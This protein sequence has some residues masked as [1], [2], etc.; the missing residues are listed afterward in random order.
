MKRMTPYFLTLLLVFTLIFL[1]CLSQSA[2][3][4]EPRRGSELVGELGNPEVIVFEGLRTYD[5]NE[6]LIGL[7]QR[8]DF[9]LASHPAGSLT[10]YLS[11]LEHMIRAGYQRGGFLEATATAGIHPNAQ[12]VLLR[13][14]EG[15]RYTCGDVRVVGGRTLTNE[16]IRARLVQALAETGNHTRI[17]NDLRSSTENGTNRL[18]T[19]RRTNELTA[20]WTI[21]SPAPCDEAALGELTKQIEDLLP[22]LGYFGAKLQLSLQPDAL[23]RR[24]ELWIHVQD[25][26]LRGQI[27]GFQVKGNR[28][29]SRE[30]VLKFLDLEPGAQASADLLHKLEGRLRDSARFLQHDLSLTPLSEP[31]RLKLVIALRELKEAPPLDQEFTPAIK[32]W[33]KFRDWLSDF[34]NHSDDLVCD[35]KAGSP[36]RRVRGEAFVSASGLVF[37]FN[38]SRQDGTLDFSY[39][40]VASPRHIGLYSGARRRSL[41]FVPKRGQL[42]VFAKLAPNPDPK[43][44]AP[45]NLS[46]GA[47]LAAVETDQPFRPTIDLVPVGF[48]HRAP[49]ALTN[50]ML[51]AESKD[52]EDHSRWQLKVAAATGRLESGEYE[53]PD[54]SMRVRSESGVF[55]RVISEIATATASYQ[56]DSAEGRIWE[57]AISFVAVD[58][59]RAASLLDANIR[60]TDLDRLAAVV[61]KLEPGNWLAPL[62]DL[63]WSMQ[64]PADESAFTVPAENIGPDRS[65]EKT[66][67]FANL[68][69][70]LLVN[71]DALWPRGSWPWTA[72]R[73]AVFMFED[74]PEYMGAE[75]LRL[76]GSEE[77]GLLGRWMMIDIAKAL[78]PRLGKQIARLPQP[79][80]SAAA[81][82]KDW[83]LLLR[84]DTRMGDVLQR[85]I[86]SLCVL[87][88]QELAALTERLSPNEAE[89]IGQCV[90][91]MRAA[92]D[93]SVAETLW[94][95]VEQH[96]ESVVRPV[97]V[98]G[99]GP[100]PKE[101]AKPARAQ[102]KPA[103]PQTPKPSQS[104][105]DSA[106][107]R[108]KGALV[109]R[110]G[111]GWI[112]LA[113]TN[114]PWMRPRAY[115]QFQL[116]QSALEQKDYALAGKAVRRIVEVWPFSD[117]APRAYYILGR[118]YEETKAGEL[119]DKVAT[120]EAD[121][122]K[123]LAFLESK[124][125]N[126]W[127]T[128]YARSG[129]GAFFLARNNYKQA[130]PLLLAGYEGM[131]AHEA[132]IPAG[133]KSGF[134]EALES[135][136]QWLVQLYQETG[137]PE[138]AAEWK[139]K[140]P[141]QSG[142]NST[143]A[144]EQQVILID[145]GGQ[146]LALSMLPRE[147]REQARALF[148]KKINKD[149]Q[150]FPNSVVFGRV[151]LPD[152]ET[153][154]IFQ[155]QL[156]GTNWYGGPDNPWSDPTHRAQGK[157]AFGCQPFKEPV[158]LC[159][160]K[161][162]YKARE[163]LLPMMN[164]Q[165]T[166]IWLGD[167]KLEKYAESDRRMLKGEL[168]NR[169]QQLLDQV[170]GEASLRL[171][172]AEVERKSVI[173][174]GAF[175]FEDVTPGEYMIEFRLKGYSANTWVAKVSDGPAEP[176]KKITGYPSYTFHF[177]V[178]PELH[179]TNA[180]V[181]AGTGFPSA[182]LELGDDTQLRIKQEG[183]EISL[184]CDGTRKVALTGKLQGQ[185]ALAGFFLDVR[186]CQGPFSDLSQLLPSVQGI[187]RF[188]KR[189]TYPG[190]S[191]WYG[192]LQEGDVI[193]VLNE[194]KSEVKYAVE[195]VKRE[196]PAGGAPSPTPSSSKV[197]RAEPELIVAIAAVV[198]T[199][200]ILTSDIREFVQPSL[201]PLARAYTNNPTVL[202][203]K[204]YELELH[205][206]DELVERNLI[207]A[208]A[209]RQDM[210]PEAK[211]VQRELVRVIEDRYFDDTN[212]FLRTIAAQGVTE[213]EYLRSI[214]ENMLVQVLRQ[215]KLAALPA[216]SP[217]QV[218]DY[219]KTNLANFTTEE[220]VKLRLIALNKS[221]EPGAPSAKHRA[222]EVLAQLNAGAPFA[223][224]AKK[225]S[226]E[227]HREQWGE[228][229]WVAKSVL[230]KEL[231]EVTFSLRPGEHSVVVETPEAS[232][233]VLVEEKRA[234]SVQPL[235]DVRNEIDK[236]L[237]T[238]QRQ[239]ALRSWIDEMRSKCFVRYPGVPSLASKP[240]PDAKIAEIEIKHV[241]AAPTVSDQIIRLTLQAR[242][243]ERAV[244]GHLDAD[245]RNLYAM[246]EFENI[247]VLEQTASGGVKLIYVLQERPM[248]GSVKFNGNK[249][250]STQ[251][252][253][254]RLTSK[255]GER[256]D[257]RK[258]LDDSREF[259]EMLREAEFP[260]AIVKYVTGLDQ[261]TGLATVTF[262]VKEKSE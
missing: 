46:F 45:L 142:A 90:R 216:P 36:P 257:E 44:K 180:I 63:D 230:R 261:K 26:G 5:R 206:L 20:T 133:S 209:E 24:A 160:R 121:Y 208:E 138:Q 29:N 173:Q 120:T 202:E 197:E 88:D 57:S 112:Y 177:H 49:D 255:I 107:N 236:L 145:S 219:Y 184:S 39:A 260:K 232:Y 221:A 115:E 129:F 38:P 229:G 73:E 68:R 132:K 134:A 195:V 210:R 200:P 127:Q 72:A 140:L 159:I 179:N 74:H 55:A 170:T 102:G 194:A 162:G 227:S 35:F 30:Q 223:E 104:G 166:V 18:D 109:Y 172:S 217:E 12:Q 59:I 254:E 19:A 84:P 75:I 27:V 25:E 156:E 81:F 118:C 234:A 58:L 242:R 220:Q 252:L 151:L 13:V 196:T 237:R 82:K 211:E 99:F 243:G 125:P 21:G 66:D 42:Q 48:V 83:Q 187:S 139:K 248:L 62:L 71:A 96:W 37:L 85:A 91:L 32:A 143:R 97:L 188:L 154:H 41:S 119:A 8:L 93:Q 246:G 98:S 69:R 14:K 92:P 34:E 78:D 95:A 259:Q 130:E 54:F 169:D 103:E 2:G 235:E 178:H 124:S 222:E 256:F 193:V 23:H 231:A 161:L 10:N 114:E 94:P 226:Q 76:A 250:F 171:N 183:E 51:S 253:L 64:S 106:D 198:N 182:P 60:Q 87:S 152:T 165:G 241:G 239:T 181:A 1:P 43:S 146:P 15:P 244:Q 67:D 164:S 122:P 225:H 191:D 16:V 158:K 3:Q 89:F 201:G 167:I 70:S 144:G 155:F 61:E 163:I 174:N 224:L 50:G 136:V 126:E 258:L 100:A 128:F 175:S 204:M 79:Q 52:A 105:N 53:T 28:K 214:G 218:E 65:L 111:E 113:A 123:A 233:L 148:E 108:P 157:F 190:G 31:G 251:D 192:N 137:R 238:Q 228:W 33:L 11:T 110:E 176:V 240:V 40:V 245:V 101:K 80:A 249:H 47:G 141:A 135:S 116:A 262:E 131:K 86:K 17:V 189:S 247:N 203:Q 207:L 185:T 213:D 56:K 4:R 215:S 7:R 77:T 150:P 6:V 9:H 186:V 212:I 147:V 153:N 199:R 117:Y 149:G 205:A 22:D 168:V